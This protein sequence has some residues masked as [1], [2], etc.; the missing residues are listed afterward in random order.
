MAKRSNNKSQ[1]EVQQ[2]QQLMGYSIETPEEQSIKE[3]EEIPIVTEKAESNEP[4]KAESADV[5]THKKE[6]EQPVKVEKPKVE[7]PKVEKP[8]GV[9][10]PDHPLANQNTVLKSHKF[11]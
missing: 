8:K 1:E 3:P 10:L 5:A 9:K 2:E 11:I 6:K 4:I 7:K